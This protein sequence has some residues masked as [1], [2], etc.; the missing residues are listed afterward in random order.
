MSLLVLFLCVLLI[1]LQVAASGA[2]QVIVKSWRKVQG[3]VYETWSSF[4]AAIDTGRAPEPVE[5][6]D[7]Q[8]GLAISGH[9]LQLKVTH[10]S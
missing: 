4:T 7:E 5:V 8:S 1:Y 3:E 10:D 2:D 6:R 9:R